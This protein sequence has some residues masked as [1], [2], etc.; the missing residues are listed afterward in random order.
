MIKQSW[1][2]GEEER[3]RILNLHETATKKLYLIKEQE[4]PVQ[5]PGNT[6]TAIGKDEEFTYYISQPTMSV[7]NIDY[8]QPYFIYAKGSDNNYICNVT[9]KDEDGRPTK[10]E[11]MKNRPLPNY[12]KGE[13]SFDLIKISKKDWDYRE[14]NEVTK[15]AFLGEKTEIKT[16]FGVEK[17]VKTG[18]R[19]YAVTWKDGRLLTVTIKPEGPTNNWTYPNQNF[20]DFDKLKSD[21]VT[22]FNPA[23]DAFLGKKIGY[24]SLVIPTLVN[25]Y[26]QPVGSDTPEVPIQKLP[27]PPPP[28]QLGDKFLDNI[29]TPSEKEILRLPEFMVLKRF[30][31]GNDM[32]KYVF[33]I[34]SSASKCTAGF[35]ENNSS[36]GKWSQDTETYPDVTVDSRANMKD[37]G[38]LNLTKARAQNLKNFL[39][40]SLPKLKD[41]K[42]RVIAQGSIGTCGTEAE[43]QK[44]R[45]VDLSVTKL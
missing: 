2:I 9:E 22:P 40:K 28:I 45:K 33:D 7:Q 21:T 14:S 18:E 3:K 35:K 32:S 42:F 8:K 39:I 12:S 10:V 6:Q 25:S 24:F 41:A 1:N 44:Y 4:N 23:T 16:V 29:S 13:F 38:N 36:N 37:K 15:N 20:K 26:P 19:Y 31:E 43:N 11:V 34:Q 5:G 17:E 27:E 30:V